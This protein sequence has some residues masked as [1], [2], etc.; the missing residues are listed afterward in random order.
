MVKP[1]AIH[2]PVE[3]KA[4]TAPLQSH[5]D[6][7]HGIGVVLLY[8][9]HLRIRRH[10]PQGIKIPQNDV[11]HNPQRLGVPQPPIRRDHQSIRPNGREK[12]IK[13]S[14]TKNNALFHKIT[15]EL[16]ITNYKLQMGKTQF[17]ICNL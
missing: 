2:G 3:Q 11:R 12:P 7:Q 9:V 17:I 13:P 14:R 5:P 15:V 4:V 16:Q 8:R 6:R 10:I 1:W